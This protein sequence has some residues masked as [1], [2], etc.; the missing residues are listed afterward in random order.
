MIRS[1]SSG[2]IRVSA[3]ALLGF[4]W[5]FPPIIS[6]HTVRRDSR[7]IFDPNPVLSDTG[8]GTPSIE[9]PLENGILTSGF[10]PRVDPITHREGFHHGVDVAATEGTPIRSIGFG[11]VAYAGEYAGYG[12]FVVIYHGNGLTSHYGHCKEIFVHVGQ[13]IVSGGVVATV[14]HS[15]R[16]TGSHL[17]FELRMAGRSMSPIL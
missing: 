12:R 7:A 5:L 13:A 14:G 8:A 17:H 2:V 16:A 9:A 4:A 3:I 10:G 15:G 1:D 11:V 6:L